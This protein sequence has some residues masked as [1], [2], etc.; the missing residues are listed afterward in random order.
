MKAK[1]AQNEPE[2][3]EPRWAKVSTVAR[4][5]DMGEQTVRDLIRQGMFPV[6]RGVTSESRI[7]LRDVD[8][9]M[10]EAKR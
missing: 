1:Q 7:D 8:R 9:V 10:E 2:I 4:Y 5:L 3:L 6:V